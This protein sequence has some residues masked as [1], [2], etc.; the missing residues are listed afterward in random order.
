MCADWTSALVLKTI[1]ILT[2]MQ[3]KQLAVLKRYD[4]EGIKWVGA[5]EKEVD[6]L[7]SSFKDMEKNSQKLQAIYKSFMEYI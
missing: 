1:T 3:L 2:K 7:A 6:D 4:K 5:I